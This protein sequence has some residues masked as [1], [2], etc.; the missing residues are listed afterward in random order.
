MV[1]PNGI[2][3]DC[4]V[5][6]LVANGVTNLNVKIAL[7]LFE[8]VGVEHTALTGDANTLCVIGNIDVIK[9]AAFPK[10][11]FFHKGENAIKVGDYILGFCLIV[12]RKRNGRNAKACRLK[13]SAYGARVS[14]VVP[15][16]ETLVDTRNDKVVLLFQTRNAKANA[17]GRGGI[18]CPSFYVAKTGCA[19]DFYL[20]E[21]V[22][23][24][25]FA[26]LFNFGSNNGDLTQILCPIDKVGEC[27]CGNAVVVG[28]QYSHSHPSLFSL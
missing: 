26:A 16:V 25:A 24:L 27:G 7:A 28:N 8:C 22:N 11:V 3:V 6:G 1:C 23:G 4:E 2:G 19:L 18:H 21:E 15:E 14:N 20:A 17:I 13:N 9:R 12:H 5:E 10:L